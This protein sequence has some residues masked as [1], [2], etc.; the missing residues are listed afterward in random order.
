MSKRDKHGRKKSNSRLPVKRIL[1]LGAE[2]ECKYLDTVVANEGIRTKAFKVKFDGKGI[3]HTPNR[4]SYEEHMQIIEKRHPEK[5][6]KI[7]HVFDLESPNI[8]RQ[9]QGMLDYVQRCEKEK[10][11]TPVL[12]MP[13]IEVWF[14]LHYTHNISEFINASSCEA[15]LKKH[16]RNYEK[17]Q[18]DFKN[19]VHLTDTA[20]ANCNRMNSQRL[21]GGFIPLK[22]KNPMASIHNLIERLRKR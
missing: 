7:Y 15:E 6:D 4:D 20:I 16:W 11:I 21:E 5:Y 12:Q 3:R 9:I 2:T 19:I 22:I 18:S 10:G 17:A 1:I 14:L 8:T 13:S